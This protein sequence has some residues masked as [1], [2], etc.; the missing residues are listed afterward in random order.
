MCGNWNFQAFVNET[1][2]E[3]LA[4]QLKLRYIMKSI[5]YKNKAVFKSFI[6]RKA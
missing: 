5:T 4:F 2:S 3:S 6:L 1:A